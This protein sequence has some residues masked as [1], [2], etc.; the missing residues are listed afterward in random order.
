MLTQ[1]FVSKLDD[2]YFAIKNEKYLTFTEEGMEKYQGLRS[3]VDK[4]LLKCY[5]YIY[6]CTNGIDSKGCFTSKYVLVPSRCPW[7]SD[8][9]DYI[10]D[11]NY[12][13]IPEEYYDF[14]NFCGI[15]FPY[16]SN[17]NDMKEEKLCKK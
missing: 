2:I 12:I 5:Y 11:G 17:L 16:C 7:S 13:E 1:D 4:A 15:H 6:E 10:S 14:I 8:L 3:F 9:V